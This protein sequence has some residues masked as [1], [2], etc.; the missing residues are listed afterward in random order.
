MYAVRPR[1]LLDFQAELFHQS[2]P[3][4]FF[5]GDIGGIGLGRS[6]QRF[7]AFGHK[8]GLH[9]LGRKRGIQLF[10]SRAMIAGEVPAGAASP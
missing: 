3:F 2:A 1:A 7:R 4:L 5:P 8:P 9:V 10:V 6:R